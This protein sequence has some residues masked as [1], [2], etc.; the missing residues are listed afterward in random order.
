MKILPVILCGGSGARLWPLS[1][2]DYPKQLQNLAGDT[3]LLQQTATRLQSAPDVLPPIVICGENQRFLIAEQLR[4]AG[5]GATKIVLEPTPRST[6]PALAV[7]AL[8]APEQKETVLVAMPADHFIEDEKAFAH[9][10]RQAAL[11]A[12][13][14]KLMTLGIVPTRPHTGF[15]YIEQGAPLPD[16]LGSFDAKQFKEKPNEATAQSYIE[17][18]NFL[19][20]AGI[21]VFRA[22]T[23]INE[24]NALQPEIVSACRKAVELSK[25]DLDFLRLDKNAFEQS[26]D[27]SVD[28]AVMEKSKNVGVLPVSFRWNDLGGWNAL[29]EI[30]TKDARQNVVKGDV[31][32]KDTEGSYI[33]GNKRLITTIG[34]KDLVVVDTADA[35][36]V[37]AK[38]R[39]DEVKAI[40]SQIKD[41]KRAEATEHLEVWRPWGSYER[42]SQ[43][44]RFQVKKI[45]VKPG[46]KLSLQK[47][48]HR[49]EHWIVVSGTAKIQRGDETK[50]LGANE[51]VYIP[52]GT[53][54]RLENPGLVPLH[55][56]E[57][58]SGD[59][60][61]EDDIVRLEDVYS[62][63][64][65]PTI[66]G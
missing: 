45:M 38:D 25:A 48:H 2:A 32:L 6:A 40:F 26:P 3:S 54:H 5:V 11:V 30:G 21:F 7:A 64:D 61:G 23:Y 52:L 8:L 66:K 33:Q 44:A 59:Y 34:L 16:G 9:A 65:Q 60:L 42:L 19:W 39:V 51:S 55:L 35:L 58:Q 43:G 56:I 12:M 28:Y 18:G 31:I 49:A 1:R 20:N 41:E 27:I 36:L 24:L 50:L 57:V 62:R 29:W 63:A 13:Q 17:A 47:H 37:A 46:G 14:G 10:I 15:G 22:D 4:E 53:V